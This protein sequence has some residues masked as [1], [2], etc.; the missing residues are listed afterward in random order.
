MMDKTTTPFRRTTERP[1]FFAY[2]LQPYN[3]GTT[4]KS[5][6]PRKCGT[7]PNF[8]FDIPSRH[9]IPR[10]P[11]SPKKGPFLRDSSSFVGHPNNGAGLGTKSLLSS[12]WFTPH[13]CRLQV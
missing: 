7:S 13:A 1:Y 3:V 12:G 2:A 4:M 6:V 8:R 11:P 5:K 9:P 10:S